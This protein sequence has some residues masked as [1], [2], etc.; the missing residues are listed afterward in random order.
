MIKFLA[1]LFR[2]LHY[3][4]GISAPPPGTSDRKFVFVWLVG[5]AFVA[6][7]FVALVL[8]IPFLY[9]RH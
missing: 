6:A 5:I 9:F 3:I 8:I 4:V 1:D 2:G 7:A